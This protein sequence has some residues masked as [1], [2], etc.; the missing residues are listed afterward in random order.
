MPAHDSG[1]ESLQSVFTDS[2]FFNGGEVIH[3]FPVPDDLLKKIHELGDENTNFL[4]NAGRLFDKVQDRDSDEQDNQESERAC[5]LQKRCAMTVGAMF[6]LNPSERDPLNEDMPKCSF[7]VTISC[8]KALTNRNDPTR[9]DPAPVRLHIV[10]RS[11]NREPGFR[12]KRYKGVRQFEDG[13]YEQ[14][15]AVATRL[16][17]LMAEE[18]EGPTA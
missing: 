4:Q 9:T 10:D 14:M 7:G 15:G 13:C 3:T 2:Y 5:R 6:S 12:F 11:K 1:P 16:I 17:G 18:L 8:S